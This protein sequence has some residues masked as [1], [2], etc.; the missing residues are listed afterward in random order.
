MAYT[1]TVALTARTKDGLFARVVPEDRHGEV[2]SASQYVA[3]ATSACWHAQPYCGQ[4]LVQDTL[5]FL[6]TLVGKY[7]AMKAREDSNKLQTENA[8]SIGLQAPDS[9]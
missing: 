8:P 3:D 6:L 5:E 4:R 2:L 7:V 1:A 9:R